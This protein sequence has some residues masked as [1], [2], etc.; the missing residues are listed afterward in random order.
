MF[1][2]S[3]ITRSI[4]GNT[5]PLTDDDK[6]FPGLIDK[7]KLLE[8]EKES[9]TLSRKVQKRLKQRDNSKNSKGFIQKVFRWHHQKKMD[10]IKSLMNSLFPKLTKRYHHNTYISNI[11]LYSFMFY[12]VNQRSANG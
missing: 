6:S 3:Q 5:C 11:I 8:L 4:S 7:G 2:T 12:I 1:L 9:D 10:K